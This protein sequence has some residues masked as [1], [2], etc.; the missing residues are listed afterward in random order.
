MIVDF[1]SHTSESDGTLTPQELAEF[2]GERRVEVFS[3]SDHDTLSAYGKFT[4]PHGSVTVSGVEI[5]TTYRGNEV[6]L[7][8]YGMQVDSPELLA[9]LERNR[10]ARRERAARMAEQLQRAGYGVTFDDVLREAPDAKALGRPHV[11]RALITRGMAPD[12]DWAF[13]NLLRSGMPG[14]VP[15]LYITP[16]QAIERITAAGGVAVL[17]HPGR[18]KNRALIDEL[19]PA[20]LRGLEVFYPL[21]D[22][23]D[24]Q[25]FRATAARYGLVM[26]AGADFHDIRYHTGG[27]GMEVEREDITPFLKMVT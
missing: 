4:P 23:E 2:M 12:I 3:I 26:T 15:S 5:N 13:R 10:H 24:I 19:V 6:H 21:H 7:L 27:V 14:Y 18:L 17:A 22:T 25:I 1:H 16:Q 8:G 9:V 20:G 11:A